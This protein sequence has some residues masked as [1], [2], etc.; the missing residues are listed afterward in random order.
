V[1]I[2]GVKMAK[3]PKAIVNNKKYAGTFV[4]MQSFNKRTVIASGSNPTDVVNRAASKGYNSP[5]VIYVPDKKTFN[6]Y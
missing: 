4:A 5:V 1:R 3:T 6:V 2:G